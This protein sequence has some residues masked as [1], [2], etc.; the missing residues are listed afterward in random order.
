MV[1]FLS[2]CL[3][4]AM[5]VFIQEVS[6]FGSPPDPVNAVLNLVLDGNTMYLLVV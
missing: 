4:E 1:H 2:E 5:L 3:L 6:L